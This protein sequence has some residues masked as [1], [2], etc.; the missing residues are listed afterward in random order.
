MEQIITDQIEPKDEEAIYQGL[1][2]Y[3]LARLEDQS[4]KD[5]GIYDRHDG[6]IIAGLIGQTHGNWLT[7]KYLWV[8]E[9]LRGRHIGTKLLEQAEKTAKMRG[10][11]YCFLDTFSFQA[12]QFYR[13]RGYKEAFTLDEYPISQK[14]H[15]LTKV[16]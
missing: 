15:Y 10:C 14:R 5:I 6:K 1:L 9:H 4:P 12:P 2:A 8:D 11:R 13:D 7:I 16:L 3:N